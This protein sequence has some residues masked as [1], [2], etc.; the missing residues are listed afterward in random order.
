LSQFNETRSASEG[1]YFFEIF[2]NLIKLNDYIGQVKILGIRTNKGRV[3]VHISDEQMISEIKKHLINHYIK[4]L[5]TDLTG[6]NKLQLLNSYQ[7]FLTYCIKIIKSNRN[8]EITLVIQKKLG[9]KYYQ[10]ITYYYDPV[11]AL[12]N[13]ARNLERR[14]WNL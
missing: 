13:R 4:K 6:V 9:Y 8:T 5:K 12:R 1:I 3:S 7:K 10:N 14:L 11:E 2:K